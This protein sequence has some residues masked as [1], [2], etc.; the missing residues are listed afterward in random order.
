MKGQQQFKILSLMFSDDLLN[1]FNNI[2]NI[3]IKYLN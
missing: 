3:N 2:F 1:I